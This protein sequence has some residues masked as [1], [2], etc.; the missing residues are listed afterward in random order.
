[1]KKKNDLI[2]YGP[3]KKIQHCNECECF[4]PPS[5]IREDHPRFCSAG[6]DN[7][8]KTELSCKKARIKK[9]QE[10]IID[11]LQDFLPN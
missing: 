6:D 2:L 11:S 8:K 1:M 7:T 5:R 9:R 4:I 3:L 10:M